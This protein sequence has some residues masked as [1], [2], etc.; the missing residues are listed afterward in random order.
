MKRLIIAAV[1]LSAASLAL[2]GLALPALAGPET[3][4]PAAFAYKLGGLKL[5]ALSDARFVLPNDGSVFGLEH[6]P[7]VVAGVLKGAHAPTDVITL[8]VDA[9]LVDDGGR[10]TLIDT[11]LGVPALSALTESLKK[12]GH[13]P[14]DIS[15]IL[16]THPH[17]DHIGGLVS[18]GKPAFPAAKVHFSEADWAFLRSQSDQ[19]ALVTAIA[20]QVTT[21][22]PGASLSAHIASQAIPGHT[23]G[24]VGYRIEDGAHKLLV[25]GDAA[26]SAIL[27]LAKPDWTMGFDG[28][29]AEARQSRHALLSELA[30]SH[31]VIFA[32]HFPY[33]GIGRIEA[34]GDGFVWVPVK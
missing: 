34:R 25:I 26:H 24:H 33:P 28:D 22:A 11:G 16:I 14:A 18:D 27:S 7:A 32:P 30:Q 8:S 21:F 10:L 23:P 31:T 3:T 12:A 2:S 9:L 17:P 5:Y 4:Q 15:D 6:G 1:A 29:Q 13:T 20:P 19:A